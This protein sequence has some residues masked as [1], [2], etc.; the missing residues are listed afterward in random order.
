MATDPLTAVRDIALSFP[1]AVETETFGNHAFR[2]RD[3][4]FV[5]FGTDDEGRDHVSAKCAPGQQES[6]LDAG[7]P[8][9]L[10]KYVGAQ[11]WIGVHVDAD[12]DWTEIEEL[13]I[14]SYREIAPGMLSRTIGIR[15]EGRSLGA[16]AMVRVGNVIGEL[17]EGKPPKDEVVAEQRQDDDEDDDGLLIDFDPDDPSGTSIQ[18]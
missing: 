6:L 17:I 11:G 14:D 10:P 9:F 18:L 12:T 7:E 15:P 1:E 13:I 3:K 2:V 8:F 5:S 4:I 16:E